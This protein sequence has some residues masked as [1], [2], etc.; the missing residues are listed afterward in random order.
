MATCGTKNLIL[1]NLAIQIDTTNFNS[2][3]LNTGLTLNSINK[4]DRAVSDDLYLLDFGLT[5]FD[6][7]RA[8]NMISDIKLTKNDIYFK[9]FRVGAYSETEKIISYENL[10][11][12]PVTGSSVGNY[13]NLS[14][15]CFQGF[16]KLF[17]YNYELFPARSNDGITIETLIEILPDS[18]G[19]FYSMGLRAEDKYNPYY[20]G[21]AAKLPIPTGNTVTGGT[22]PYPYQTYPFPYGNNPSYYLY[23]NG[24]T[25]YTINYTGLTTSEGNFLNSNTKEKVKLDKFQK[26]EDSTV[27]IDSSSMQIDNVKNN[28]ISFEIT[29][30]KRLKYK[31]IDDNANLIQGESRNQL[32][33]VGWTQIDI[34][35]KPYEIIK[36][37]DNSI[38]NCYPRRKGDLMFYVNGRLFWKVND[39]DEFYFVGLNN[40]REK[41]IGVPFNIS[42][43]GG[44][45][46]LKNSYHYNVVTPITSGSNTTYSVS[47]IT[48]GTTIS[49]DIAKNGLLIENYFND[50][51]IGNIQKLRIYS[52]SLTFNEI[53]SNLEYEVY[54]N[55]NYNI[56]VTKGGRIINQYQTVT[57]IPQQTAGSDIRKTIRYRNADGTYKNLYN[58]ID[59]KVLV[60]SRSNPT[61]ELIK[62]SKT[63][64]TGYTE[65]IF[66]NEFAYD[67]IVPN[68][69]TTQH[70][71]EIL[72][73][74]ILFQ[75]VDIN[76]IDG[77]YDKIFIVDI[78]DNSLLNNTIKNI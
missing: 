11:I 39:F 44:S 3:N 14:G 40:D 24:K 32:T 61:V 25:G 2:W 73:A 41:Q 27:V 58:M 77:I 16:F 45:F 30:D 50:N 59:I 37:Y 35:F 28:I 31:L 8:D 22:Y 1:D 75:W 67:F 62:F 55:P 33:K 69:I 54:M 23:G 26:P 9:L 72:F 12:N 18:K 7:G 42:W 63:G 34:V 70:P 19:I 66:I 60:K 10:N 6:N 57:Y 5:A 65:L 47:A 52:K 56:T 71:N 20:D 43:G 74:E 51:Y 36:N 13:F 46:G 29:S 17:D 76:D 21:E 53:L 15:G 78:T 48:S 38:Y 68:E 4:W 64:S 49:K